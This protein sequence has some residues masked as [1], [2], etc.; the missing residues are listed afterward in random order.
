MGK[1][2]ILA[3][4]AAAMLLSV[5]L[6]ASAAGTVYESAVNLDITKR[7]S[8]AL[9]QAGVTT[10]L[11]RW[12]DETRTPEQR[13]WVAERFRT[14]AFV[15]IHNNGS[16][17][18]SATHSEVYHQIAGGTSKTLA[19]AIVAE[20][21]AATG[22]RSYVK[23]RRGEKGDYYWQ[24]RM[25]RRPSV[26]V[27]SAF[28]SNRRQAW[29]LGTSA[30]YRQ[31]IADSVTRGILAWQ[32]SLGATPPALDEPSLRVPTDLVPPPASV[33]AA[34]QSRYRV[35]L[36]WTASAQATAYHVRRDGT[37][38]AIVENPDATGV[39]GLLDSAT[40]PMSFTDR[41]AA[42]GQTYEYEIVA[43]RTEGPA[44]LES[45]PSLVRAKT[46]AISVCLD[47]GHGGADPGALGSW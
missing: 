32:R 40:M 29:L 20:L 23:S 17:N 31:A 37:L 7:V 12:W 8:A 27:E 33:A 25:N 34:V 45:P 19:Q 39:A 35:G 13:V 5:A 46:P 9:R 47:A 6:P 2:T 15:S 18:R 16:S 38:I 21:P 42:P 11:T 36:R 41:W 44:T 24:L 1:R 28:M 22:E 4:V 10:V 14:D 30:A 26:I 3:G 43:V